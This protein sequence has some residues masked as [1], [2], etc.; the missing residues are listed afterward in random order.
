MRI[1][2]NIAFVLSLLGTLYLNG[3]EQEMTAVLD[4]VRNQLDRIKAYEVDATFR[5]DIDFV[6]MPEKQARIQFTSPD[7]VD[8]KTDGFLMIPKIGIRPMTRQMDLENYHSLYLGQEMVDGE[9]C[10][11]FKLIPKKKNSKIVLSTIWINQDY[12]IRKWESFTKNSGS[13]LLEFSY[14]DLILPA[15]IIFSFEVSGMNIPIKYFGSEIEVDKKGMKE[16]ENIEG[17]VF[18][19]FRNYSIEYE[20]GAGQ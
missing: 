2:R 20:T 18:V 14:E 1:I 13:I 7:K 16:T 8:V 6:N 4:S 10:H 19:S 11:I 17:K 9:N 12:L 3:Q 5:V 15:E